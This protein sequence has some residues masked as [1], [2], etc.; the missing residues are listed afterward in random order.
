MKYADETVTTEHHSLISRQPSVDCVLSSSR[1]QLHQNPYKLEV[2]STVQYGKPV[3]YG[4][5]KWIGNFPGKEK[6]IYA[7]VEMV[8]YYKLRSL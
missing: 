3:L 6:T 5:I 8:R 2:G 1:L 7:G 4:V